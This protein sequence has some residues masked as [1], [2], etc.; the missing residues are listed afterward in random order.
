MTFYT[1]RDTGID[2][3][4]AGAT[5]TPSGYSTKIVPGTYRVEIDPDSGYGARVSWHSAKKAC[6]DSTLVTV[7]GNGTVNLVAATKAAPDPDPVLPTPDP[8]TP[9]P[10]PEP[11]VT[12]LGTQTAKKP[13]AKLK[14]GKKAT[15]AK[16][17]TQ[18]AKV[19]W[20]TSTKKICTVK[21]NKVTAKKKGTCK[22]SAKAP[23][24][25]GFMAFSKRYTIKIR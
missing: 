10:N 13:P 23:A 3:R 18:G 17:T 25:T 7:S 9:T 16:K 14:K 5:I 20:K 1:S 12:V 24:V 22:L 11:A 4:A 6:A 19:T 2:N 8:T 15:L 21:K